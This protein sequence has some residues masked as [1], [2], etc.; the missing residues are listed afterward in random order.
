MVAYALA[1]AF[2][3]KH[4]PPPFLPNPTKLPKVEETTLQIYLLSQLQ[5]QQ[6]TQPLLPANKQIA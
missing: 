2:H 6:P 5:L 1:A 4:Y 3:P